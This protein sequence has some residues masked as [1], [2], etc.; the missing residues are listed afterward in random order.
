M[1][2]IVAWSYMRGGLARAS[3][4]QTIFTRD[5]ERHLA[6]KKKNNATACSK[7]GAVFL[8]SR[9]RYAR[10]G[11]AS[12]NSGG[13]QPQQFVNPSLDCLSMK[14]L[15]H[16]EPSEALS[17]CLLFLNQ[18]ETCVVV[19]PVASLSSLFSLGLG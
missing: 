15:T 5:F 10:A 18:L 8:K 13:L 2:L 11:Y 19:R 6:S 9:A 7:C 3:E 4:D 17:R 14:L 16:H 1:M 12:L